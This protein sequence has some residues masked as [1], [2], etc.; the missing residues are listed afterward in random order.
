M[1][2]VH[3]IACI[4]ANLRLHARLKAA[5]VTQPRLT[6]ACARVRVRV[7]ASAG[8]CACTLWSAVEWQLRLHSMGWHRCFMRRFIQRMVRAARCTSWGL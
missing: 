8:H 6:S 2:S 1:Q 5:R 4:L 3:L 7:L